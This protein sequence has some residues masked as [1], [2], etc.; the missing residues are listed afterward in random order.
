MNTECLTYS[1]M[2]IVYSGLAIPY[3]PHLEMLYFIFLTCL[4]CY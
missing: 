4:P 2:I 3:S 1:V